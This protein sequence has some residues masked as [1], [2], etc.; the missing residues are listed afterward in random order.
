MKIAILAIGKIKSRPIQDLVADY[1]ERIGHYL[2]F[3]IVVCRD[4]AS[5]LKRLD[6][7]DLLVVLDERGAQKGSEEL[8]RFLSEH[9][10]RGTRRL[11]FFIGGPDGVGPRVRDRAH[12]ILGLSKM[13]LPHELTQAI[14]AEQLYR[15]CSINR[16][17][18]YHRRV[19]Q[20][21]PNPAI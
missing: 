9:Q 2:P 19:V 17:E 12:L 5:A 18:R 11:I 3:E 8:A 7:G 6:A 4:E 15:A 1:A 20:F 10:T 21:N 13:T 16:G 14:L